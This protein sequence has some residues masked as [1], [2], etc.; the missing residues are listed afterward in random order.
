MTTTPE[1]HEVDAI[2]CSLRYLRSGGQAPSPTQLEWAW[3]GMLKLRAPLASSPPGAVGGAEPMTDERLAEFHT[4]LSAQPFDTTWRLMRELLTEIDRL[5]SPA[6]PSSEIAG[7]LD[8]Y[9]DDLTCGRMHSAG[10][11]RAKI[12][13]HVATLTAR[14]AEAERGKSP[15]YV[16]PDGS[17]VSPFD[18][19]H[20]PGIDLGAMIAAVSRFLAENPRPTGSKADRTDYATMVSSASLLALHEAFAAR[21]SRSTGETRP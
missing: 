20:G 4:I 17:C 9:E 16:L 11:T 6:A 7:L 18:C 1:P 14:I 21:A 3:S 19:V 10:L 8:Q 15:C 12:D 2:A 5:R 13:S